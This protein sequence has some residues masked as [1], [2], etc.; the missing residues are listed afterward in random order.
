MARGAMDDCNDNHVVASSHLG[1]DD[2]VAF[3][4]YG[5]DVCPRPADSHCCSKDDWRKLAQ[6]LV[7]EKLKYHCHRV[8][9]EIQLQR[10][11]DSKVPANDLAAHAQ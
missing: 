10:V 9:T 4:Q 5:R 8:V 7:V 1:R 2:G 3:D 11:Q 6:E